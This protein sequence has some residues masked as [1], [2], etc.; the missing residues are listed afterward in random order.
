MAL[1]WLLKAADARSDR[2]SRRIGQVA[3]SYAGGGESHA[4]AMAQYRYWAR[5]AGLSAYAAG[6]LLNAIPDEGTQVGDITRA[7]EIIDEAVD[8]GDLSRLW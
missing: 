4:M 2:T 3:E 8:A 5:E 6:M 1:G 7:V